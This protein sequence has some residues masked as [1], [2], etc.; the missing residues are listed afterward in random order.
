MSTISVL[1]F[2]ISV[3]WG[4]A[5]VAAAYGIVQILVKAS[6]MYYC[7]INTPLRISDIGKTIARP[8]ITSLGAACL[9][10]M[11]NSSNLLN[12]N[13]PVEILIDGSLYATLYFLI[14]VSMP[15]GSSLFKELFDLSFLLINKKV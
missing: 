12:T 13:L 4:A 14:W 5:G 8:A 11:I 15:N 6:S 10:T 1:T 7:Y 3:Q 2:I 9:L